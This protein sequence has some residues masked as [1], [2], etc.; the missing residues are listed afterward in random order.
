M[1]KIAGRSKFLRCNRYTI[2][3]TTIA[4]DFVVDRL[5]TQYKCHFLLCQLMDR[6]IAAFVCNR[7]DFEVRR[8]Q[9]S[10]LVLIENVRVA[11]A[12]HAAGIRSGNYLIAVNAVLTAHLRIN[13]IRDMLESVPVTITATR[14][15]NF[16]AP[17]IPALPQRPRG[18]PRVAQ[19]PIRHHDEVRRNEV[20][21][22]RWRFRPGSRRLCSIDE[23]DGHI[24]LQYGAVCCKHKCITH[25]LCKLTATT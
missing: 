23:Y 21:E 9:T 24:P 2:D 18:L 12:A 14:T 15:A 11:S 19:Y 7:N 6:T 20:E 10:P 13:E 8:V 25:N 1:Q 5:I 22:P 16:I 3:T 17:M 4:S